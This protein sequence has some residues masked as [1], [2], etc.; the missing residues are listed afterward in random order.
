MF[1][2]KSNR[3]VVLLFCVVAARAAR[4]SDLGAPPKLQTAL[5]PR[6]T[7]NP[8]ERRSAV[9][10]GAPDFALWDATRKIVPSSAGHVYLVEKN[11]ARSSWSAT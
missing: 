4:A 11:K 8:Q 1:S 2:I 10:Q 5:I 7:T 6:K 3:L 9:L